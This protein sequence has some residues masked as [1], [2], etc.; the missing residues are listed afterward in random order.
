VGG[1]IFAFVSDVD[2]VTDGEI[3][4]VAAKLKNKMK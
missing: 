2:K 4:G 3:K 1:K